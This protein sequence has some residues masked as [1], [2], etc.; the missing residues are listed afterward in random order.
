MDHMSNPIT[1]PLVGKPDMRH[2]MKPRGRGYTFRMITPDVL[3]GTKNPWT[4]KPFGK[5][6]KLGL[7]TRVHAEALRQRDTCLGQVRQLEDEMRRAKGHRG[8]GRILDLS[9]DSALEWQDLRATTDDLDGVD[10]VLTNELERAARAGH[11][12]EV[13]RFAAVVFRGRSLSAQQW[14][15]IWRSEAKGTPTALTH[16]LEPLP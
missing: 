6:I 4:G 10:H 1:S 12:E 9:H 3:V 13:E 16:L 7:G 11:K 2:L 8:A 15:C 5:E 14:S